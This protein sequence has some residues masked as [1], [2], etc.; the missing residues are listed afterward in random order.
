MKGS[1]CRRC[2]AEWRVI[3]DEVRKNENRHRRGKPV[4]LS[5]IEQA[6]A[7]LAECKRWG[8]AGPV[9]QRELAAQQ[10]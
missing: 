1:P 4:D 2:S 10:T 3:R 5:V 7:D 8:H 9:G 6:K